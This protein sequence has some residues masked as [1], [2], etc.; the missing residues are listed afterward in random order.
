MEA[1]KTRDRDEKGAMAFIVRVQ[2]SRQA[3]RRQP[4]G[5]QAARDKGGREKALC[6]RETDLRLWSSSQRG[7]KTEKSLCF[8][9]LEHGPQRSE[10]P[11]PDG[12][13]VSGYPK[14]GLQS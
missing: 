1:A 14:G 9:D 12:S 5:Q 11:G 10:E 4:E 8:P 3:L 6:A 7:K 2:D 13:I